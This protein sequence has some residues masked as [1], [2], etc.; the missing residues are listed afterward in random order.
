MST[1]IQTPETPESRRTV[2]TLAM[3]L[4]GVVRGLPAAERRVLL[5]AVDGRLHGVGG[6]R[7]RLALEV[8]R[9]CE[10]ETRQ[11]VSKRRYERWR[12]NHPERKSL[13]SS[14]Y[15]ANSL[16]GS[17]ARAMDAAG[18]TPAVEHTTFR[19]HRQGPAPA[20]KEVLGE[21]RRCAQEQGPDFTFGEYRAWALAQR[22]ADPGRPGLLISPSTFIIRFGSFAQA[23]LAAGLGESG[24]HRGPRASHAEYSREACLTVLQAAARDTR[25]RMLSARA[26]AGVQTSSRTLVVVGFGVRF[27]SGR[28]PVTG[29]ALGPQHSRRPAS[30]LPKR[31]RSTTAAKVNACL[32]ST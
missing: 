19:W 22:A 16:G 29:L 32:T 7:A 14:T 15:V 25:G 11:T 4:F 24:R 13:P 12:E 30:S 21:L 23:R 17:W 26:C 2:D 27:L 6:E 28:S 9:R 18:V 8:L 31:P 20:D 10:R 3:A 5:S 1:S